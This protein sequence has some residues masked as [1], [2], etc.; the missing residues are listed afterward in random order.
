MIDTRLQIIDLL[1]TPI[2]DNTFIR[3][4]WEKN[5]DH[6]EEGEFYYW[7]LALEPENNM[8]FEECLISSCNDDWE[9]LGVDEGEYIV[10]I[11]GMN[12]LGKCV[13]EEEIEVLFKALTGKEL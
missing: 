2:T 3:Q 11:F 7:T 13:T 9:G 8:G 4:G 6:D 5:V 12:G 10:E 1:H